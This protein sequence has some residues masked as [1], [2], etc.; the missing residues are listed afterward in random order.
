MADMPGGE[1]P[2]R[3]GLQ[4]L[5]E[6]KRLLLGGELDDDDQRP[7]AI[8]D[9]MPARTV[10]VPFKTVLDIAGEPDVMPRG[11]AVAAKHVDEALADAVQ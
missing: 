7:W 5:L 6:A 2:A 1:G 9:G 8:V 3:S 10:V 11:V 4:V